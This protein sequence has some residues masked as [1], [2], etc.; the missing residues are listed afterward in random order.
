MASLL[1]FLSTLHL[2]SSQYYNLKKFIETVSQ[3][4][5]N[6]ELIK[7]KLINK[8]NQEVEFNSIH[9]KPV[10]L[11]SGPHLS[12]VFRYKTNDITKNFP[13]TEG[14]FLIK[15]HL[16]QDFSQAIAYQKENDLHFS[17]F[18]NG[19]TK[20]KTTSPSL[21][22]TD[23]FQHDKQ[24]SRLIS[25]DGNKYLHAL[26]VSSSDGKI[27]ASMQGK[28]RQI[29]KFIEII[30]SFQ[31][32]LNKLDTFKVVD[33]GA[34]KGYLSFAL[35]EYLVDKFG[36]IVN[37]EGI[38][39]RPDLVK[40]C[41]EIAKACQ[42]ESLKFIENEIQ[43]IELIDT[44]I[45][46]ALHA[47][48]TATD[49]AIAKGILANASLIVCSPCCHKQIRKEMSAQEAFGTITQYGILKERQAEIITDTI[50]ATILE[51]F[52]YK[53]NVMEFISSEHTSKNLLITATKDS[54]QVNKNPQLLNNIARL[55]SMF[56][57]KKHHLENL[58]NLNCS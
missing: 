32:H 12:F 52:G 20:T 26:G 9:I 58:L 48:D 1:V 21:E 3:A 50:R 29:N 42:F 35:Y 25:T 30:D 22:T 44:D 33:M 53:T 8:K 34:G 39:I 47:C 2:I 4:L 55:K 11:K 28:Y 27:K 13:T 18:P 19:K 31:K 10:E 14:I 37:F 36:K 16:E 5:Q 24:K 56:G 49:E 38:E 15:G 46:I 43:K 51:Y 57:I 23:N 7:L 41:N 45:L 6:K 54:S 17:I 40:K